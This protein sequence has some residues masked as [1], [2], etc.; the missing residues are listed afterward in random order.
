MIFSLR[1]KMITRIWI[2]TLLLFATNAFALEGH[3][4]LGGT[5]AP[6]SL[7]VEQ[8]NPQITYYNN[9]LTD[10]YPLNNSRVSTND[11]GINGGYEFAGKGFFP[12]ISIGIGAYSTWNETAFKG[13]VFETPAGDPS[14]LLY[15]YQFKLKSQ[16]LM[17]EMQL[18]W[19][20]KKFAPF[21]N[22]GIGS[23]WNSLNGYGETPVTPDG[24]T[25]LPGFQSQTQNHFAYQLGLGLGYLFSNNRI[26]LGYR[27]VHLGNASFGTRGINYPYNLNFGQVNTSNIYFSLT[28]LF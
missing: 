3:Y 8:Q 20:L 12:A 7:N 25:P 21:I 10:A 13:Q 19:M 28:H 17:A 16:R 24:Y 2:I 4:Y 14:M 1:I 26:A 9:Y 22:F 11:F 5:L 18:T 23:A 6:G 15:N 27:Y